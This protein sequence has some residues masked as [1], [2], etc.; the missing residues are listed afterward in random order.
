MELNERIF[1]NFP[2]LKTRR[3]TLRRITLDDAHHI[4][5]M[6]SNGRM[7][8]WIARSPMENAADAETLAAR[9]VEAFDSKQG[10]GWAGHLRD[11]PDMI[12]TCGFNMIDRYNLRA[13][14]GGELDVNFWGKGLAEEA[15]RAIVN[16][17]FETFGL[18]SIEAKVD[19]TNRGAIH[20]MEHIGFVKEAYF[21]DRIFFNG[22]FHDMA[23]YS[24]LARNGA[25]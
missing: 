10:I 15:V 4:F 2:I 17:G 24:I 1:E 16:F 25:G 3:M 6:R 13:E 14:I 12:G 23:V 5:R 19:P 7:S 8:Q 22:T 21:R 9:V 20:L 18:H 11:R